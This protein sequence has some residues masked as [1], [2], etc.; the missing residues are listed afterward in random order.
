[1]IAVGKL[2]DP[3]L[4][5]VCDD[6]RARIGRHAALLELEPRDDRALERQVTSA[7]WLVALDPAGLELTSTEFASRLRGW[8]ELGKTEID[9]V[10]GGA[11]GIPHSV[12]ERANAKVALSRMTLPHRLARVLLYEQLYRAFAILENAPYARED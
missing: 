3:G 11:D 6:Y 1:V 7:G 12:L 9:F 4:R 8:L 5:R 10:I 2:R